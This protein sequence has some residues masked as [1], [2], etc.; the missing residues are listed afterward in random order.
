[1]VDT[2]MHLRTPE[3]G[4]TVAERTDLPPVAYLMLLTR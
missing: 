2:N 3:L 4:E 1:M